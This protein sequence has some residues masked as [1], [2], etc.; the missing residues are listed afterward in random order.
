MLSESTSNK[1]L[2]LYKKYL[3]EISLFTKEDLKYLMELYSEHSIF[4]DI[5]K[6]KEYTILKKILYNIR[7]KTCEKYDTIVKFDSNKNVFNFSSSASSSN[8]MLSKSII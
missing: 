5:L 1:I 8:L 2:S 6:T 7:L 4:N 3:N